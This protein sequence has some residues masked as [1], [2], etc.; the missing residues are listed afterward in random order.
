MKV[1]I[2]VLFVIIFY[3]TTNAATY[4]YEFNG[5]TTDF[6]DYGWEGYPNDPYVEI[7]T[8]VKL[9]GMWGD[10]GTKNSLTINGETYHQEYDHTQWGRDWFGPFYV[11][12]G[13]DD[14]DYVGFHASFDYGIPNWWFVAYADFEF[15][16]FAEDYNIIVNWDLFDDLNWYWY[17][18]GYDIPLYGGVFTSVSLR[19]S[20]PMQVPEPAAGLLFAIG[21]A[22]AILW[23][24]RLLKTHAT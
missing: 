2:P 22:G 12:P 23:K 19:I 18:V 1:I 20:P 21:I 10:F 13:G 16:Y 15:A 7:G 9:N 5:V 24:R 8:E 4:H 3:S 6:Y 14:Y 17:E 11:A